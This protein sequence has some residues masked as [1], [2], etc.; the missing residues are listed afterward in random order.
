MNEEFN[1]GDIVTIL[2]ETGVQ[3][4]MKIIQ[5][6]YRFTNGGYRTNLAGDVNGGFTTII[7]DDKA[8]CGWTDNGG[9]HEEVFPLSLLTKV[10]NQEQ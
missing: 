7:Y 6:P 3:R 2:L 5:Y 4:T 9:Y 8:K 10:E 1:V